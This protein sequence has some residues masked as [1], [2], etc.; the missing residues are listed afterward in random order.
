MILLI[1]ASQVAGITGMSHCT[2]VLFWWVSD[3]LNRL[4][5]WHLQ[6]WKEIMHVTVCCKLK[7]PHQCYFLAH[8][9]FIPGRHAIYTVETGRN[10]QIFS[11]QLSGFGFSEN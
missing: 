10:Q 4:A 2:S 3:A 1:S 6:G 11:D 5:S 8:L 9:L 7:L